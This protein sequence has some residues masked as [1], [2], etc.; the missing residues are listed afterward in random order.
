MKIS[1]KTNKGFTLVEMLVVAPVVILAIGAFL[2]VVIS[3]TGEVITSRASNTLTYNIQDALS[4]IEEDTKLSAGFLATNSVSLVDEREDPAVPTGQGYNND[5]TNF[6][7]VD[8]GNGPS[9]ILNMVATSDNPLSTSSEYIFLKDQP[10]ACASAQNNVPLT[11]NIV[12]FIRDNSLWRRVV[13]PAEYT[14]TTDYACAAAWQQ[15]SCNPDWLAEQSQPTFC[16][17]NDIRLVD[18]VDPS[19]FTIQYFS[20]T[21]STTELTAASDSSENDQTRAAALL[22]ATTLNVSIEANQTAAGRDISQIASVRSSRLETNASAVASLAPVTIPT[23]PIISSTT[24]AGSKAVFNWQVVQGATGYTFEY[25]INGGSWQTG[26]TNQNTRTY[27][28][29]TPAHEDT[30]NARVLAT[31]SAGSSAYATDSVTTPLWEPLFLK[32]GWNR[33]SSSYSSPAYTKTRDGIVVVKGMIKRNGTAVGE[34]VVGTLPEGYRPNQSLMFGNTTNSNTSGRIDVNTNGDIQRASGSESWF[35]L[36]L[37]RFIPDDGRYS[38][39]TITPFSNGWYEYGGEWGTSSYVVTDANRVVA[40]GLIRSGTWTN[41]TQIHDIPNSLLPSQYLHL[42]TRSNGF[43]FVGIEHRTSAAEGIVAKG[44]GS[45]YVALTFNYH[46]A[47]YTGWSNIPLSN[48]WVS[49]SGTTYSTVQYT[50]TS[51]NLV[52]LKGLLRNGTASSGTTMGT[53]PAG[54]RPSENLLMAT[55]SNQAHARVDIQSDGR[56]LFRTGS[57]SWLSLDG[58]TFVAEQ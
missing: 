4:R 15:P 26:F 30:V 28:V 35:S 49:D 9:L 43:G 44:V 47:S 53:L 2:T 57:A 39:T 48:G 17:T 20:G 55:V 21:N 18:G 12:Y 54:C 34:E 1:E 22:A 31:N 33:Y 42:A 56:I 24:A 46:P 5:T 14:D 11:Y 29:D 8:D 37:I 41:G 52:S 7:N 19:D 40:Q 13:M 51:D 3:M 45:S 36:D 38:R 32:N 16:Q 27:T 25:N 50:K 6:T 58:I 23:S 10:N